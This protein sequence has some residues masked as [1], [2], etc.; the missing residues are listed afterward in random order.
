MNKQQRA[1]LTAAAQS[2][3]DAQHT[4]Q[5]IFEVLKITLVLLENHA[6]SD[7]PDDNVIN[8]EINYLRDL[9]ATLDDIASGLTVLARPS[10]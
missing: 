2:I 6:P 3:K 10:S 9:A 4:V 1:N 7:G 5:G 8:S